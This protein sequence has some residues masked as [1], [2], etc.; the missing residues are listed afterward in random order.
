MF[1]ELTEELLDLELTV[2]GHRNAQYAK[3]ADNCCCSCCII[4]GCCC[5]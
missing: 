3:L 4:I 5:G 1:K 2:R